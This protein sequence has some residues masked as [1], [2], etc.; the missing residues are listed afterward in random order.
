MISKICIYTRINFDPDIDLPEG[1]LRLVPTP[2]EA[3]P[4]GKIERNVIDKAK[5]EAKEMGHFM[6][7]IVLRAE[8]GGYPLPPHGALK[9]EVAFPEET[10]LAASLH[11]KPKDVE[12]TSSTE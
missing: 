8:M 7:G 9:M 6:A 5:K 4:L 12:A 1:E 3:I 11:F 10:I 2:G